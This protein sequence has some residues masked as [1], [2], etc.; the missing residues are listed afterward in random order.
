MFCS[1]VEFDRSGIVFEQLLEE[2]IGHKDRPNVNRYLEPCMALDC[3][4]YIGNA[5]SIYKHATLL[6]Q[7]EPDQHSFDTRRTFCRNQ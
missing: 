3:A 6:W 7:N 4:T 2:M 5:S 1:V